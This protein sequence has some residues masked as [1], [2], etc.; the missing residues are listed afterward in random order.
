MTDLKLL[1]CPFCG[2][3]AKSGDGFAPVESIVYAYCSNNQCLL[4]S[5]DVGFTPEEWN[6]R[7]NHRPFAWFTDDFMIDKSATTYDKTVAERW[8][9]KGWPVTPLY[10][11]ETH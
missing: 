4:H 9:T 6:N 8:R 10:K 11:K 3:P 1:D 7:P 2:S 5:I